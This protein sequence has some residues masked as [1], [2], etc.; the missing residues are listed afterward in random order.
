MGDDAH[1]CEGDGELLGQ[2]HAHALG[3]ADDAV[4]ARIEIAKGTDMSLAGIVGQKVVHG[5][6]DL[7]AAPLA[8]FD[9]P[10][11]QRRG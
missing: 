2:A 11:V 4:D 10:K 8:E 5:E 9:E 1:L 6:H 3:V 7:R